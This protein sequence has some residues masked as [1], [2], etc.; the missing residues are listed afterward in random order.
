LGL[1]AVGR[2]GESVMRPSLLPMERLAHRFGS[3]FK[4]L[5]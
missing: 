2:A 4:T 3:G 5:L 1:L